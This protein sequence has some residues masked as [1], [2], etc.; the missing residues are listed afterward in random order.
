MTSEPAPNSG[1]A[2]LEAYV[3]QLR[4]WLP[5]APANLIS[6]YVQWAPWV[7]IVLGVF[8]VLAFLLLSVLSTALLPFLA[9]GGSAGVRMGGLALVESVLGIIVSALEIAGGIL[10][11]QRRE[12]GW[13]ILA[14]GIA[15]GVLTN[16]LHVA[17]LSL[18]FT[19]LIAYIHIQARPRYS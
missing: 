6:G 13:W 18:V 5:A 3:E 14:F 10:M 16:L 2:Q 1:G 12:L 4:T 17:V 9:F 11:L 19:L 7:A 8:G 15:I